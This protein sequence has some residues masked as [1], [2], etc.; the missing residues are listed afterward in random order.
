M[1]GD[2][3]ETYRDPHKPRP[4][5][6]I[7]E[8]WALKQEERD[9]GN[10]PALPRTTKQLAA[11]AKELEAENKKKFLSDEFMESIR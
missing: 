2:G 4:I 10:E 8:D 7:Y 3:K 1:C 5:E 9:Y 11:A 6:E